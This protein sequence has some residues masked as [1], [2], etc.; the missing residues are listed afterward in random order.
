MKKYSRTN[1]GTLAINSRMLMLY[2]L[3]GPHANSVGC[4]RLPSKYIEADLEWS[5]D[6]VAAALAELLREE[7]IVRSADKNGWTMVPNF[8]DLYPIWNTHDA[9]EAALLIVAV[10]IELAFYPQFIETLKPYTK[11]FPKGFLQGRLNGIGNGLANSMPN[12]K[13]KPKKKAGIPARNNSSSRL[14]PSSPNA[15]GTP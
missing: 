10:P 15:G 11:W 3:R 9:K 5:A 4:F 12:I 2:L 1:K 14:T 6:T 13:S 7:L 8:L